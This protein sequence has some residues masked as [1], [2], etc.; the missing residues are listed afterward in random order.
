MLSL[1]CT[2]VCLQQ[3]HQIVSGQQC[4]L[5]PHQKLPSAA[6]LQSY[7]LQYYSPNCAISA[8]A[9]PAN[10]GGAFLLI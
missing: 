7:L 1:Y 3:Q 5:Q 8:A 10:T 2:P 9:A 6:L 4:I